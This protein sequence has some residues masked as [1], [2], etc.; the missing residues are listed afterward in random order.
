M[1]CRV[2]GQIGHV[3]AVGD[4]PFAGL[5]LNFALCARSTAITSGIDVTGPAGTPETFAHLTICGAFMKCPW[6]SMNDGIKSR[7]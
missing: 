7:P 1:I 4:D 3:V 6:A 5:S 2:L